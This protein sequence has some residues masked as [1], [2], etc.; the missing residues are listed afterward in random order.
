MFGL[1]EYFTGRFFAKGHEGKLNVETYQGFLKDVISKT[2]KHIIL[3]QDNVPYHV[4]EDMQ[5][6]FYEHKDRIAI[7]QLPA[8]SL[9]YNPIEKLWEKVKETGIHVCYF[10]T[11]DDLKT[12]V[13]EIID[14]PKDSKEEVLSLFGFYNQ[15]EIAY[16]SFF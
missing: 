7:Y 14:L 12:K 1:I 13:N 5:V 11:F 3:I 2:R 4:S 9:D 6:F 16:H 15:L 8:Y 10:P